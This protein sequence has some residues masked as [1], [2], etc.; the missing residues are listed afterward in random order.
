[1]D[2]SEIVKIREQKIQEIGKVIDK[3]EH[4]LDNL[5]KELDWCKE[6][7]PRSKLSNKI[8][9]VDSNRDEFGST[10]TSEKSETILQLKDESFDLNAISE[11]CSTIDKR[12]SSSERNID[13]NKL[14]RDLKRRRM[15]YRTTKVAPL[16]YIEELRELIN[17]QMELVQENKS[18]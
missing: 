6:K 9:S 12:K 7:L 14:K 2:E 10:S 17:L 5:L 1:M 13:F 8:A 16:T 4:Q 15:K 11:L 18:E 3:C